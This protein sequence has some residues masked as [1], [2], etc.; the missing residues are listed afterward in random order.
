MTVRLDVWPPL[1]PGVHLRRPR[2]PLPFPLEEPGLVLLSRARNGIHLG[3]RAIGLGPGDEVLVPAYHHGSEVEALARVGLDLR[4]YEATES[5]APEEQELDR[6]VGPHTRA[7]HLIHYLGFP[8]DAA[9]WRRWCDERG[10]LLIEDA[11]QAWLAD[12]EGRPVGSLGDVS[13]FCLYKTHG[14]PDG[15]AL[16]VRGAVVAAPAEGD[17]ARRSDRW[18]ALIR[19]HGAWVAERSSLAAAIAG[20]FARGEERS[21]EDEFALGSPEAPAPATRSLIPR[22]PAGAAAQRRAHYQMLLD[23]LAV[24]VP[25]P[26]SELPAG[27]SPFA[28]PVR[29][30]GADLL[31]ALDR[32]GVKAS[33]LWSTA[34]PALPAGRFPAATARRSATVL[35]P[36]HQELRGPDLE[37]I[38]TAARHRPRAQAEIEW[39]D[40]LDDARDDWARLALA[41]RNVFATWEWASI[42][43]RH[44]GREGM[45]RLAALRSAGGRRRALFPLVVWRDRPL[46]IAR[47][48]GYGT[49]DEL[50]PV[51]A[52]AERP[53]AAR[54]LREVLAGARCDVLLGEHLPA[55]DAWA[56]LLDGTVLRREGYP[57]LRAP[58]GWG[59]Y[60]ATRSAHARRKT[61]WLE[62][63]LA[64]EHDVRFRLACDADRLDADLD[65]VFALHRA[66]W[67]EGSEFLAHEAV[68]R[69]LAHEAL[70]QGWLRLWFLDLDGTPAACWYGFR[71]AGVESHFQFGR[72][73]R[74][75]RESVGTVLLV[76]T[77]RAA[78]T[79]GVREYR[80][81]RGGESYKQRF[82]TDDPGLETVAVGRGVRGHA[83]VAGGRLADALAP[84]R[85]RVAL[86][87]R[88]G[89]TV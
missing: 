15:A 6:L 48:L 66:R 75:E 55:G 82:A 46:R 62:R 34:H 72:D 69:D 12:V 58:D 68:H 31:A 87:L 22:L 59:P 8:Q 70:R 43:W 47:F 57:V 84:L 76:H 45:L 2:S 17:R 85:D 19:R 4:F 29:A 1:P 18:A 16:L 73:P 53:A 60:L 56:T 35:L 32:A 79:D 13:V 78:L 71:F 54:A 89:A 27:A 5:L 64:R 7:L 23:Q 80:F 38:A 49:A 51:C 26:F 39:I 61:A 40:S 11:A 30:R 37:R 83:A 88:T 3:A 86:A 21:P 10:L 77:I 81:L 67:P 28:F 74:F 65:T 25:A 36:V 52:A 44:H 14:L 20:R 42:W 9:R 63:R 33:V 41:S 24:D 50:G